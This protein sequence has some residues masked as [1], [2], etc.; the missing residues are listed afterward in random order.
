MAGNA[1]AALVLVLAGTWNARLTTRYSSGT[2][3]ASPAF[4]E[5]TLGYDQGRS[6]SR[7]I[8]APISPARYGG[9][10]A[11]GRPDGSIADSARSLEGWRRRD[12]RHNPEAHH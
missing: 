7:A 5:W 2:T 9:G 4:S 10:R 3:T 12:C 6:T 8:S 1:H 11:R